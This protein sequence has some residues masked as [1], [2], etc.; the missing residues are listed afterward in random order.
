ME[1][2]LEIEDA[3]DP[4]DERFVHERLSEYN[5]AHVGSENHQRLVI[6]LRDADGSIVAGLLGDTY[7]GWL[8]VGILWV[9]ERLRGRGYGQRLLKAAEEEALRRGCHH[10]HLDTMDFQALPFYV[11]QE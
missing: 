10:A 1:Y 9:H 3:P 8:S 11:K 5:R 4:E 6:F 2:T 7:W